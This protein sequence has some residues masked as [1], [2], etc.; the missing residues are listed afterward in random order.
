MMP[1]LDQTERGKEATGEQDVLEF[2][3]VHMEEK[4][5]LEITP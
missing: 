4:M 3:L 1:S 2:Q 5:G